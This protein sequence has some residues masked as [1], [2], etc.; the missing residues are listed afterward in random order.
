MGWVVRIR[1]EASNTKGWQARLPFGKV[2]PKS[3]SRRY[4]SRFFSDA[5]HGGK[6]KAKRAAER[7]LRRPTS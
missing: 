3:M 5:V 2:N 7:W 1:S 6:D 4:R